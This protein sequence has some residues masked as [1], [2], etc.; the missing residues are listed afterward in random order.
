MSVVDKDFRNILFISRN[1]NNKG[2][3]DSIYQPFG[4]QRKIK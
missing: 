3:N 4:R 2:F 1:K